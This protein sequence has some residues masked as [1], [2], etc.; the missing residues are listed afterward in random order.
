MEG[1]SLA[2]GLPADRAAGA[3]RGAAQRATVGLRANTFFESISPSTMCGWMSTFCPASLHS[4]RRVRTLFS[5]SRRYL[6]E[7]RPEGQPSAEPPRRWP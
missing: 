4:L 5:D 7:T 6:R 1:A 3:G 2:E